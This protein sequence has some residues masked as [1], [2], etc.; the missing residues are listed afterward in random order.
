MNADLR[1]PRRRVGVAR[2][3]VLVAAVGLAL[4][5]AI[6]VL[7]LLVD[8]DF[9]I[10]QAPV[11]FVVPIVALVVGVVLSA[12][13]KTIGVWLIAVVALVLLVMFVIAMVRRG[14][15]QQN[16]ADTL[17]VFGGYAAR[18][19]CPSGRPWCASPGLVGASAPT[20]LVLGLRCL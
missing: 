4:L 11:A 16:W 1:T 19:R 13:G 3:V 5:A 12:R 7:H 10:A 15:A 18:D 9:D 14:F 6:K 2:Q 17:I 8:A 20:V